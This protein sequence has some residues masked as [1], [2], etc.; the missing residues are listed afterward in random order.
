MNRAGTLEPLLC[1]PLLGRDWADLEIAVV[2][3]AQHTALLK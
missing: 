1:V 2:A 3:M